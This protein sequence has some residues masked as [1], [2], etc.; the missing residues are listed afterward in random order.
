M[1]A[2]Q[3]GKH[4]MGQAGQAPEKKAMHFTGQASGI[5]C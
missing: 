5:G 2:I 3:Q 1:L 4:F